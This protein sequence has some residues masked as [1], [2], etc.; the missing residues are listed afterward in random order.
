MI[1]FRSTRKLMTTSVATLVTGF[2]AIPAITTGSA[3]PK[4][5]IGYGEQEAWGNPI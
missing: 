2:S 3:A 5:T 4:E 1:I